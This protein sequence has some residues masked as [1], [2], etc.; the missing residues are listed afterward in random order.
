MVVTKLTPE[1]QPPRL[2]T[3]T[4][5]TGFLGARDLDLTRMSW[6]KGALN[7]EGCS[8]KRDINHWSRSP[9]G[10]IYSLV[11]FRM[12]GLVRKLLGFVETAC[13]HFACL[14]PRACY[15][16]GRVC[17]HDC[18][19]AESWHPLLLR[20]Y[21]TCRVDSWKQWFWVEMW[22]QAKDDHAAGE[23]LAVALKNLHR[24]AE[25]H[26]INLKNFIKV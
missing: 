11:C 12:R 25:T 6:R 2:T 20:M 7:D 14:C 18:M 19:Q 15:L 21:T 22:L 10:S 3:L 26:S 4:H 8:R 16:Q 13:M 23:N 5:C 9:L 1:P 24:I 17:L